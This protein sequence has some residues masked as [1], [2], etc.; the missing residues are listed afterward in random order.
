MA[1]KTFLTSSE[2]K[3]MIDGALNLR[4]K[5][6]LSF[7]ADT[8][9][10]VSE[11]LTIQKE[12]LDLDS[13]VLM[14]RH[15]K[16]GIKKRCPKCSQ[17]A[18]RSTAFCSK[19][20]TDLSKVVPEGVEERSRLISIG[21][22]TADLLREYTK[23]MEDSEYIIKLSRQSVYNIVRRVADDAGLGNKIIRNTD[24]GKSHYVHPHS[25]RDALTVDWLGMA[26]TDVGK[27]K[28]LQE[29][30]GHKLFQTTVG[31]FKLTPSTVKKVG[32]EVRR[33]RFAAQSQSKDDPEATNEE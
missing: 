1:I 14:I 31:Y 11:L 3:K 16:R 5:V 21:Q 19:C 30:L 29:H 12:D 17:V 33:Q 10:R 23:D 28:A 8:G 27:Q 9:S 4:D 13:R 7:Y 2:V 32:D 15:L 22:E 6:I 25:F 18:G 20:G 24:S 26:G